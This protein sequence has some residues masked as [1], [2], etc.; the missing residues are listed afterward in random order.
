MEIERIDTRKLSKSACT[1]VPCSICKEPFDAYREYVWVREKDGGRV[2]YNCAEKV[3][4]VRKER[5]KWVHSRKDMKKIS[6]S[7]LIGLGYK[8]TSTYICGTCEQ[9]FPRRTD[10]IWVVPAKNT[11]KREKMFICYECAEAKVT[12]RQQYGFWLRGF[13]SEHFIPCEKCQDELHN[14]LFNKTE[15][16]TVP[17]EKEP[18]ELEVKFREKHYRNEEIVRFTLNFVFY[19]NKSYREGGYIQKF[20]PCDNCI[21]KL[22][23]VMLVKELHIGSEI[24]PQIELWRKMNQL[25]PELDDKEEQDPEQQL[26]SIEL[27]R[28][29]E[30]K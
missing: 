23:K 19:Y 6:V 15:W 1:N 8:M 29:K 7:S 11:I 4:N 26:I 9:E 3:Y 17:V 12:Y 14:L 22:K 2:C 24:K 16:M 5:I 18:V 28:Q 27:K 30:E 13:V 25:I 20:E 10:Y 21:A